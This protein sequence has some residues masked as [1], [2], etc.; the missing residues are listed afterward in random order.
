[1]VKQLGLGAENFHPSSE[2]I[3]LQGILKTISKDGKEGE[4]EMWVEEGEGTY[5]PSRIE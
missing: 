3:P 4:T 1:M 5:G 2:G